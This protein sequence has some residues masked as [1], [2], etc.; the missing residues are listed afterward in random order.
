MVRDALSISR[1]REENTREMLRVALLPAC[2]CDSNFLPNHNLA[3]P[4]LL[5][6]ILLRPRQFLITG[7]L[8]SVREGN[9]SCDTFE[10]YACHVRYLKR[11]TV[12]RVSLNPQPPSCHCLSLAFRQMWQESWLNPPARR[13]A[14]IPYYHGFWQGPSSIAR[15]LTSS[16]C[17]EARSPRSCEMERGRLFWPGPVLSPG[18]FIFLGATSKNWM[19]SI[20]GT[21]PL[22]VC[23]LETM[24]VFVVCPWVLVRTCRQM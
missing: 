3:N 24:T 20:N 15:E 1:R 4:V 12:T 21:E 2:N 19:E 9:L 11:E 17:E 14:A 8:N 13:I 5:S 10:R 6:N 18:L 22:G 7:M 16:G 23:H